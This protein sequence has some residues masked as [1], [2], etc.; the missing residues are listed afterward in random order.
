[1]ANCEVL[2][3][4]S[5]PALSSLRVS[6]GGTLHLKFLWGLE[7]TIAG[8]SH[9]VPYNKIFKQSSAGITGPLNSL[10]IGF[11]VQQPCP[12]SSVLK[13]R[14]QIG[15][16]GILEG[17]IVTNLPQ[18]SSSSTLSSSQSND[19]YYDSVLKEVVCMNVGAFLDTTIEYF[20]AVKAFYDS[21]TGAT[22]T[23]YGQVTVESIIN[24]VRSESIY[25]LLAGTTVNVYQ[26][27]EFM[28]TAGWHSRTA[29]GFG[30][31]QIVTA[32]EDTT[33]FLKATPLAITGFL[34][35]GA[36][37][38]GVVPQDGTV[39]Q[40]LYFI[41]ADETALCGGPGTCGTN[42]YMR[43]NVLFNPRIVQFQDGYLNKGIDFAAW[44]ASLTTPAYNVDSVLCYRATA[45]TTSYCRWYD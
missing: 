32:A 8:Y 42:A 29:F 9:L 10:Y 36:S 2:A 45:P 31:T 3:S 22:V 26:N 44:D 27:T 40:L 14:V 28:D 39:Q 18:F 7:Q 13:I 38:V 23:N 24:G 4:G 20:V 37:A 30:S 12:I 5:T 43:M 21:T 11:T 33:Q 17:S 19:C 25:N 35:S 34:S 41:K 15:A 6:F 1:M 16:T